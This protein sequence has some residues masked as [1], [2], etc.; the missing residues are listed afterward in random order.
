MLLLPAFSMQAQKII[1]GIVVD[2]VNQKPM[3]SVSIENITSKSGT[4]TNYRGTFSLEVNN[5]HYLKVSYIGYKPRIIRIKNLEDTDFLRVVLA[6]G[7]VEL[8]KVKI[9]VPLTAY[10]KD[11]IERAKI[12]RDILKYKQEKSGFSPVTTVFQKFSKKHKN[13]R[14]FKEQVLDMEQQKYIDTRYTKELCARITKLKGDDLA[15]Y[16]NAYPM[17]FQYARTAS[18]LEIYGWVARNWEDYQKRG[19]GKE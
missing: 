1:S 19:L 10:Q 18:D 14:H 17:E 12:Y 7:K 8:Q 3:A 11:S 5:D 2:S 15:H 9:V 4:K 6:V 13:L 16:M